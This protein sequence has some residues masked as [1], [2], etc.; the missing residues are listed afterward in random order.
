[1]PRREPE[2]TLSK[3]LSVSSLGRSIIR[4]ISNPNF[5]E[6]FGSTFSS[7]IKDMFKSFTVV[8]LRLNTYPS[9]AFPKPLLEGKLFC[10]SQSRNCFL[11]LSISSCWRCFCSKM[12]EVSASNFADCFLS[13]VKW[14]F[15]RLI[16]EG[17]TISGMRFRSFEA[18]GFD[19]DDNGKIT[20]HFGEF[21]SS[22]SK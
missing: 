12:S 5:S 6:V 7:G 13:T 21:L 3:S 9:F 1:M 17:S 15:M 10:S 11:D 14:A 2:R 20:L 19:N 4:P 22:G 16:F 8:L 18:Q